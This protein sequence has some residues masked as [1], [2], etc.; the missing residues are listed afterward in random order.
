MSTL[1]CDFNVLNIGTFWGLLIKNIFISMTSCFKRSLHQIMIF[2]F[3][4]HKTIVGL[5][6]RSFKKNPSS[7]Q[8]RQSFCSNAILNAGGFFGSLEPR[9][10]NDNFTSTAP[11]GYKSASPLAPQ[12]CLRFQAGNCCSGPHG[13]I[14]EHPKILNTEKLQ[15]QAQVDCVASCDQSSAVLSFRSGGGHQGKRGYGDP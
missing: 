5:V 15:T 2:R 3:W 10:H 14:S 13:R 7:A 9:F 1:A 8:Q 11:D 12:L 6:F 4:P